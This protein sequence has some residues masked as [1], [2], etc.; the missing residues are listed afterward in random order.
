MKVR[1]KPNVDAFL[2]G[3]NEAAKAPVAAPS[4]SKPVQAADEPPKRTKKL[5]ELPEAMIADLE[6]RCVDERRQLGRRVTQTEIVERALG[7]YLYGK[8]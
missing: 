7:T 2:D 6:Q 8:A 5:F 1:G 4:K 3:G